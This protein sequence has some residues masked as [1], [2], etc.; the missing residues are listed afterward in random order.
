MVR[1]MANPIQFGMP[2][3]FEGP[4]WDFAGTQSVHHN[5][6]VLS[7]WFHALVTGN[8]PRSGF[9]INSIGFDDAMRIVY[10]GLDSYIMTNATYADVS[11]A[12]RLAARDVFGGCSLQQR[13]VIAAWNAVNLP[14][15]QPC[16]PLYCNRDL[17][18]AA[19]SSANC[20]Q[21]ITV[22]STC[23]T[24]NGNNLGCSPNVV[25]FDFYNQSG[26]YIGAGSSFN[27]VAPSTATTAQYTVRL[28]GGL[29]CF[30]P[31]RTV[32]INVN[33]NNTGG[34]SQQA[35]SVIAPTPNQ[36]LTASS[37]PLYFDIRT[38]VCD[39]QGISQVQYNINGNWAGYVDVPDNGNS[40]PYTL[41]A[42][43]WAALAGSNGAFTINQPGTYTIRPRLFSNSGGFLDASPVQITVV[44]GGG[45]PNPG[46]GLAFVNPPSFD[47]NSGQLIVS[48]TGGNGQPVEFRAPG[49]QDWNTNNVFNVPTYQRNGTTFTIQ[50]RQSGSEITPLNY[51]TS[52][53]GYRFAAVDAEGTEAD[54]LLIAPNPTHGPFT[55]R[56][57]LGSKQAAMLSVVNLQGQSVWQREVAGTGEPQTETVE[58]S[59][60]T[61]GQYVVR[62]KAANG[63][64][65][66]KLLLVR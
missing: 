13:S 46:S 22:T 47:C 64:K 37:F 7:R 3:W 35:I 60:E 40:Q 1:N 14:F 2:Q 25:S 20:G 63:L 8:T 65:A 52:C 48:T 4:G 9:P 51:T 26:S 54:G 50:A 5:S 18:V 32:N 59:R 21:T 38:Q 6:S 16:D 42:S 29:Y 23:N 27:I 58:L 61:T 12:M 34:C 43:R 28:T 19:P 11:D 31:T 57:Q 62:L 55:V 49:L 30:V 41:T 17:S 39:P 44:Q 53:A 66:G 15:N 45:N 24:P 56:F 33:C 36:T 10:K